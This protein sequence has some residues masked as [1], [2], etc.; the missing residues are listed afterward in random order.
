MTWKKGKPVDHMYKKM[1][2]F[3]TFILSMKSNLPNHHTRYL[4]C[5]LLFYQWL[6]W[7]FLENFFLTKLNTET[8][9]LYSTSMNSLWVQVS[10]F[11]DKTNRGTAT[12]FQRLAIQLQKLYI[13]VFKTVYNSYTIE[14]FSR[15]WISRG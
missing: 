14:F 11:S 9:K 12:D 6:I 13:I 8:L 7:Y 2:H 4:I 5:I 3:R 1:K 10:F 15:N